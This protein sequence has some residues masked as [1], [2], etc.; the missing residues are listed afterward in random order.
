MGVIAE[1]LSTDGADVKSDRGSS[2]NV[3]AR[4]FSAPGDDSHPLPGDYVALSDA[5]GT[6]RQTAVGYKDKINAPQAQPGERRTYA[7]NPAGAVVAQIWARNNGEVSVF[8]DNGAFTLEP[9]GDVVINGVRITTDGRV[10]AAN[11]VSLTG[12][13]HAQGND[14]GGSTEQETEPPTL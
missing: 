7:R 1:V 6:G 3:T 14:S 2:D 5:A 4:H 10:I 8:N 9:G 12:H 13:T 11:G